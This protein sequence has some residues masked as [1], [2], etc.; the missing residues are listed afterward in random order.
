MKRHQIQLKFRYSMTRNFDQSIRLRRFDSEIY[1]S[2][3]KL[4]NS[5][6][7]QL[8]QVFELFFKKKFIK[9]FKIGFLEENTLKMKI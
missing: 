7:I 1:F 3:A 6:N 4:P 2:P 5:S 9:N 8:F